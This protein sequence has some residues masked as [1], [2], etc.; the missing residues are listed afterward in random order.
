MGLT[1]TVLKRP[2]TT[3]IVVLC[4]IVFGITSVTTNKLELMSSLEMPMLI[5]NAIYPGASPE[6]VEALVVKPIEDEVGVLSGVETITSSSNENYGLLI[7]SYEYGT[8][9]DDAYNDLKK[10]ID[11]LVPDLPEDVGTPTII[12][13]DINAMTS[14]TFAVNNDTVGNLYNYVDNTIV[15]QIEKLGCVANVAVAGG[16]AEYIRVE[17][18]PEKMAQYRM[19]MTSL[20]TALASADFTMPL[21]STIV[22][23]R[24]LSV[25]SGNDYDTMQLLKSIPITLGNGNI[26]YMEDVANIYMALEDQTSIGRYNGSDTISIGVNKNQDSTD[27]EVS[28]EVMKVLNEM[29]KEDPNLHIEVINDN[30]QLIRNSL[31]TVLET[32]VMAV[33][34][35]MVIIFIFLGDIKASLIVGTSIPISILSTLI[36]I[37]VAG[38]SL[39]IITLGSMV[40]GIGMMVDNSIVVLESCFRCTQKGGFLEGKKA[41]IEGAGT[42]FQSVLGGT[43]TT[44]VVFLPL[45]FMKGLSGQLFQ[46]LGFTIVFGLVASLLSAM[47]IVPLCYAFYRPKEKDQTPVSRLMNSVQDAYRSLIRKLLNYKAAVMLTS[48]GLL[49]FSLFLAGQIGMELMPMTDD[50]II[51]ISIRTQPGLTIE[52]ID[53]IASRAEEY[54]AADEDVES[55]LLLSG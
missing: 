41:A 29:Q 38:F 33:V 15:P 23:G 1:K 19:N 45:G 26:I 18:I 17:L 11:A 44:C 8:N 24:E 20:A 34:V 42:V 25:S 54:V 16:Q 6:D 27:I 52:N 10:K 28:N 5:I 51:S 12:E 22:G 4:L 21:G 14:L 9:L 40:V 2:V 35:A 49:A 55:Y 36:A 37:K 31:E 32:M 3:L 48:V 39:N 30:S 47:S 46:P 13:L 53:Q 7:L 43:M 50:G